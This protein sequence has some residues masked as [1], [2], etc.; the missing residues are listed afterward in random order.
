MALII[1]PECGKE[2]S[3]RAKACIHCGYPLTA[4]T[5]SVKI[6]MPLF[7]STAFIKSKKYAILD[8]N[9]N[10][11]WSGEIGKIAEQELECWNKAYN[12]VYL[13]SYVIMPNHIHVMVIILADSSGRP[14]VA[15]T[16]G[17]MV[18]QFKGSVTKKIGKSI[19]Q[20]LFMDHVVRDLN[21]FETRANYIYQNPIRWC[22]DEM[23]TE[24]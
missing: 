5:K 19:W 24:E 15:P 20:K 6:K 8:S 10:I 1:C 11:L 2:I 17:Q 7:S 18:R 4:T 3:N 23:Y 12:S 21:D 9:N 13:H 16:I 14:K 22:F